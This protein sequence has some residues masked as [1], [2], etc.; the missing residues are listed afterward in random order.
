LGAGQTITGLVTREDVL[1]G[2]W[3]TGAAAPS[4]VERTLSPDA[5]SSV[6]ALTFMNI[7]NVG[8]AA[9]RFNRAP[10]ALK[11]SGEGD[12]CTLW[13]I[14]TVAG[15]VMA[16]NDALAL[17]TPGLTFPTDGAEVLADQAGGNI[18]FSVTWAQISNAQAYDV[19][20]HADEACTQQVTATAATAGFAGFVPGNPAAPAWV[21]GRNLLPSGRDYWIRIRVRDQVPLDGNWTNWSTP[22]KFSVTGGEIV[23]VPYLGPQPLGPVIGATNVPVTGTALTW[24]PYAHATKYE[25]KLA[26]DSALTDVLATAQ[27]EGTAY[28]YDG[29]LSYSTTYF[30]AARTIEPTTSDWSPTAHFTT[31]AEPVEEPEP[32]PPVI[33]EETTMTP[34]YIYAIIAVGALLVI[35]VLVLI[36]R[37]RRP[38]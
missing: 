6:V 37:T 25:V 28:Q 15:A 35:A 18:Q 38:M 11:V 12:A 7:L 14:D 22:V 3:S 23:N 36:V 1:Y 31:M 24:A 9:A 17:V 20:I 19:Q 29:T 5:P 16:Y 27:V 10:Q 2:C 33:I 21:V 30:W 8:A 34:A 4:S 13:A 32:E 26:T